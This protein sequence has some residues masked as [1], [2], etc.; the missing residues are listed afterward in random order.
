MRSEIETLILHAV[1]NA[2]KHTVSAEEWQ[3]LVE[4]VTARARDP[5]SVAADLEQRIGLQH[6]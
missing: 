2:L 4:D 6:S 1:S 3:R 5:Y